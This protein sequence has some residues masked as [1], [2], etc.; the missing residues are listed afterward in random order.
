MNFQNKEIQFLWTIQDLD[1]N[2]ICIINIK[3]KI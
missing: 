3:F 1:L 2:E